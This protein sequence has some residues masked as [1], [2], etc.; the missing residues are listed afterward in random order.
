MGL[1]ERFLGG[2]PR[3][4]ICTLLTEAAVRAGVIQAG[5]EADW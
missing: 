4:E 5:N 2:M 3:R 1:D